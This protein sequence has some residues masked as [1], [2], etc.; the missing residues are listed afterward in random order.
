VKSNEPPVVSRGAAL[1]LSHGRK[2]VVG[3]RDHEPRSGGRICRRYAAYA[4]RIE[5]TA[6]RPW[7]SSNAA[8][9][10]RTI[11][12]AG[13]MLLVALLSFGQSVPNIYKAKFDTSVGPFVIE[14]H[15][16]WAPIGGD[17]FY[18]LVSSGFF[19][20]AR[21]F[22]VVPGFMVQFGINGN[23]AV[24]RKWTDNTI[25]DEPVKI[26][27]TRGMVTFAKS[28]A[29]NSR[30]TQ[31]FINFKDNSALNR[32]GFAPFGKVISGMEVVDKIYGAYGE[33][34]NNQAQIESQGNAYLTKNFPK[35]DYIKKA[36]IE[37]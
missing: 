35:L 18:E 20:N 27:N 26:G 2:A 31:V 3:L 17:R 8:P 10:L 9:R 25:K 28:S 5:T 1:E 16:E 34:S 15:R 21:F 23:P 29:P 13:L 32:Q 11:S 6:L 14:V 12:F 30:T 36:T 7:L 4:P 24:Q 37:K 22:R 33:K 19:D